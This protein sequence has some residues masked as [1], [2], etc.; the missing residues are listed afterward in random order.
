MSLLARATC[1]LM[2][3]IRRR[4]VEQEMDDELKFHVASYT[5]DLIRSGIAREQAER[6]ARLEFGQPELFKEDCRQALGLRL[7]DETKQDLQYAARMLRKS[8]GFAAIAV[9]TLAVGIGLNTAIF[10]FVNAWVLK[11]LPYPNA[12][13][14][15]AIWSFNAKRGGIG[16]TSAADLYDWRR[17]N[18][19]FEDICAWTSPMVTLKRANEPQPLIGARVNA[20]FFRMLGVSPQL[21]RGFLPQEDQPGTEPVAV[22]SD[23]LWRD[24]FAG[25]PALIGKTIEIDGQKTTVVGIMPASF[26]LPLLGRAS[27]W[28]P[29][30]LSEAERADRNRRYLRVIARLKPGVRL[31]QA[32][33]YLKTVAGRLEKAYPATNTGNSVLVRTLQ[34]EIGRKGNEPLL[35]CFALV[36]CVLLLAC[37]NVANLIVGRALRRQQEM[38]V[39]LAIGAGRLRLL[40]QLLTE[41]LVLFLLS[42]ALSVAF[43]SWGVHWIQ[44]SLSYEVRGFLPNTGALDVDTTAL[45]YTFGIALLTGLIFGFAPAIHCWR[46]DV[47]HSL[48]GTSTQLS[49]GVGGARLK[50]L[51]VVFEMSVALV[52]VVSAGLMVKGMTRMYTSDPGFNVQVL[53]TAEA[54]LSSAR[55]TDLT[56]AQVFFDGVIER[57]RRLPGVKAV[58]AAQFIPFQGS[59]RAMSYAVDGRPE[60]V[61]GDRPIALADAVTPDY[62]RAIGIAVVRGRVFSDQDRAESNLVGVINQ[63]MARRHWANED[64]VGQRVRFGLDLTKTFTIIGV[65]KDTLGQ[66][67]TDVPVPQVYLSAR[68]FPARA[69]TLVIRAASAD[70]AQMGDLARA[71][72]RAAREVD[73]GQAVYNVWTMED[74][75]SALFNPARAAGKLTT[76]FGAISVFL[77]A[78]GIYSVM[79]YAVAARKKEFGIRMA[80]GAGRAD[81]LRMVTSQGMKLAAAGFAL[82]LAGALAVTRFMTMILYHVSP[83]DLPTFVLTSLLML[84][85]AAVASY[86][87]ARQ[88]SS[89]DPVRTLHYE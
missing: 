24:A 51:L 76:L 29:L 71:V 70:Q 59:Y 7:L 11:P 58:G 4:R 19:V 78:I 55:Y 77:A 42:A 47:N 64:P 25:D 54:S 30:A 61:P 13:R 86:V 37:A 84:L 57:V 85:I 65:V 79:A 21:G 20:E 69:M 89:V 18:K 73:P 3:A 16:S 2:S 82:G 9:V 23:G 27:I 83:T 52:V 80:L 12:D 40:R 5:D 45:L 81:L 53:L 63:T 56:R 6:M 28:M 72:R 39:R 43:A 10:T 48:R 36:G 8:P 68:Q 38:A 1:L 33:E 75:R 14:L 87:P 26:H 15:V 66:T 35:F 50:N 34:A 60:P 62:L 67:E 41:N 32:V 17:E 31:G 46:V 44:N 22:I 88:A 74:V 49:A